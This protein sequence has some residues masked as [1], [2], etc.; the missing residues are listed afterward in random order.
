MGNG[1]SDGNCRSTHIFKVNIVDFAH[2][3]RPKGSGYAFL[4]FS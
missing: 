1:D 2:N 3:L 4:R